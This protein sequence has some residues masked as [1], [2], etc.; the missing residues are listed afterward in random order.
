[1]RYFLLILALCASPIAANAITTTLEY[2]DQR[3]IASTNAVWKSVLAA[4]SSAT[5]STL[6]I[7]Q[8]SITSATNSVLESARAADTALSNTLARAIADARPADYATVSNAAMSAVQTP[9]RPS[10]Y[11]QKLRKSLATP[12]PKSAHS[13][14][15]A[16]SGL[17]EIPHRRFVSASMQICRR[18]TS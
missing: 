1:M 10:L 9:T 8:A 18:S 15:L 4:L 14:L 7:A 12:P 2:E 5:N 16:N 13:E 17:A 3:E 11:G 6:S